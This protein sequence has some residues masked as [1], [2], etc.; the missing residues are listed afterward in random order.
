MAQADSYYPAPGRKRYVGFTIKGARHFCQRQGWPLSRS[1]QMADV[2][3]A[4]MASSP[5][6]VVQW[7]MEQVAKPI[8]EDE[9]TERID[10]PDGALQSA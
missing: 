4:L 10:V 2:L 1:I 8:V 7:F 3:D 5:G 9:N 6:I